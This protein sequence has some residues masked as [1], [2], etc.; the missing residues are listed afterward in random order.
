ML[1]G[2]VVALFNHRVLQVAVGAGT[3]RWLCRPQMI[4]RGQT[5]R[6]KPPLSRVEHHRVLQ[7]LV[8]GLVESLR[9]ILLAFF[10]VLTRSGYIKL[11]TLAV[12]R[13]VE[14]EPRRSAIKANFLAQLLLKVAGT[15]LLNPL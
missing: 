14:V 7:V 10:L 12:V 1:D 3:Y 15:R 13:L 9:P 2:H 8:S 4:K 6:L 11:L 5:L